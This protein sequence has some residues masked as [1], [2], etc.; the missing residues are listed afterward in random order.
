M[1]KK[2]K[3][4]ELGQDPIWLEGEWSVAHGFDV[5]FEMDGLEYLASIC[6]SFG[7]LQNEWE[8]VEIYEV[9]DNETR[10]EFLP[11]EIFENVNE[12]LEQFKAYIWMKNGGIPQSIHEDILHVGVPKQI[13]DLCKE[14]FNDRNFTIEDWDNNKIKVNHNYE[15]YEVQIWGKSTNRI[16]WILQ[17]MEYNN[18]EKQL[19]EIKEGVFRK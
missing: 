4:L 3:M 8:F 5:K 16:A 19:I 18:D 15:P 17:K 13:V 14:I 7:D 1:Q 11:H 9:I 12:A 2:I 6:I 10:N